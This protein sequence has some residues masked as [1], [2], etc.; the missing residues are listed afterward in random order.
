[1]KQSRVLIVDDE[2]SLRVTLAANL[3]LEG[4][5]VIEAANAARALE[6][7]QRE[8]VDLVLSDIR[9]PGQSGV[10]LFLRL[11]ET[12]PQLPVILMTAFT[13]ESEVKQAIH[14]GIFTVLSKPFDV[15]RAVITLQRAMRRPCVLVV[16]DAQS[17]ATTLSNG[18]SLIGLRAR[19]VFDGTTAVEALRSGDVDVCVTD[20]VMPG[21]SGLEVVAQARR[22][23]PN[24]AV[25][26]F[27]GADVE[28]LVRHAAREGAYRCLRKPVDP[29]VLVEIIASARSE[30]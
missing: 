19:A 25:I 7:L 5:E 2:E 24:I 15:E 3:E 9:M 13:T 18:L 23:D 27:S 4:F 17:V 28:E 29:D 21:M 16:D 1:V 8:K 12:N 22:L 6:I 20:L 14:S 10:E 26:T 30:T 11:K